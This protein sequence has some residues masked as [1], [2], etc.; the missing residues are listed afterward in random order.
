MIN[1][2]VPQVPQQQGQG[3]PREQT[4]QALLH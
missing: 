3:W 4:R 1:C 2:P